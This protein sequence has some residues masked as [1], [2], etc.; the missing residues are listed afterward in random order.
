MTQV[1]TV[2]T[3]G[4]YC[5]CEQM[6]QKLV[7]QFLKLSILI[8]L[9]EICKQKYWKLPLFWLCYIQPYLSVFNSFFSLITKV[10]WS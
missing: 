1:L 6:V 9:C 10:R 7:Y 5:G 8:C 4:N 3:L 2:Y